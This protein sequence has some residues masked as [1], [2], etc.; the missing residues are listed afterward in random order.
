[1]GVQA[2]TRLSGRRNSTPGKEPVSLTTQTVRVSEGRGGEEEKGIGVL[3]DTFTVVSV[4]VVSTPI[5]QPV[6]SSDGNGPPK[7]K[8]KKMTTDTR[9]AA[10]S[11]SSVTSTSPPAPEVGVSSSG[12]ATATA[13]LR[14]VIQ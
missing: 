3:T 5:T 13:D 2:G 12:D 1:M 11:S 6:C 10:G 4:I 9:E 8:K 14:Q 7:K